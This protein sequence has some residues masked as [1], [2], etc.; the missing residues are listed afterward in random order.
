MVLVDLERVEEHVNLVYGSESEL[1]AVSS[2]LFFWNSGVTQLLEGGGW[3]VKILP[4]WIRIKL[5][6]RWIKLDFPIYPYFEYLPEEWKM[7]KFFCPFSKCTNTA[8]I[9]MTHTNDF[10]HVCVFLMSMILCLCVT[11]SVVLGTLPVCPS[12]EFG[13]RRPPKIRSTTQKK[14]EKSVGW[15]SNE[16][17]NYSMRRDKMTRLEKWK[18]CGVLLWV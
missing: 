8:R 15:M 3:G 11:L 6:Y 10:V 1:F 7:H 13:V 2:N 9:K 16:A 5:I 18:V 17:E 4:F 12:N 14:I